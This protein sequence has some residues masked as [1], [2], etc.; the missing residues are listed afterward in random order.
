VSS[1]V[2]MLHSLHL[3]LIDQTL[4]FC[5]DV[6]CRIRFC[7]SQRCFNNYSVFR[8]PDFSL[9]FTLE[10]DASGSGILETLTRSTY[11]SK[12]RKKL[13]APFK[14]LKRIGVV[15]YQLKLSEGSRIRDVFHISLLKAF[16]SQ[17]S[18]SYLLSPPLTSASEPVL[19]PQAIL[20]MR[21]FLRGS[22]KTP[23]LLVH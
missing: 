21:T 18:S 1:C 3:S 23:Q 22:S 14:V 2:I 9:P 11:Q 7:R 6:T 20:D 4:C 15:A 16:R 8:L 17:P 13:F 12:D 5:V 19:S 10:M